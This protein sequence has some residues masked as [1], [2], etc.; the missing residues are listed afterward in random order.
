MADKKKKQYTAKQIMEN[1]VRFSIYERILDT[2]GFA[3]WFN[4]L[5]KEAL[6]NAAS[7]QA[8]GEI[9]KIACIALVGE[10]R[11]S[12]IQKLDSINDIARKHYKGGSNG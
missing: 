7:Q 4:E 1:M 6:E 12:M 11:V 2:N 8:L 5:C 3:F 10:T 9:Q